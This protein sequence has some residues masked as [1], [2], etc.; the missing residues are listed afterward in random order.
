MQKLQLSANIV[1]VTDLPRAK[2]W[3]E[4][5]FGMKTIEYRPPEFLEMTLGEQVFYI[6]TESPKR[7]EGFREVQIGGMHS[8]ILAVDNLKKTIEEL[9]AN[10]VKIVVE[11]VTQFWGG[12]NAK[13]ADPDGNIFTLDQDTDIVPVPKTHISYDDFKRVEVKAGKIL[14][15]EKVEKADKLLKLGVDFGFKIVVVTPPPQAPEASPAGAQNSS[16][17]LSSIPET[18]VETK[19]PDIRQIVSGIAEYYPD[20]QVLVGITC[21]FVTN[22]ESRIIRGLESQGMIFAVGGGD[23]PLGLLV[24]NASVALGTPAT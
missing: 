14:S 22:L 21:M 1:Y 5:N 4:K 13:V 17:P 19:I 16:A 15:A 11:P 23:Q 3:Y 24:P 2:A 9:R 6:E 8:A 10:G 18:P 7:R 20:P 12:I